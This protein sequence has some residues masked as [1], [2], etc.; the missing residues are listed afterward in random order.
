MMGH[1]NFLVS[2]LRGDWFSLLS[3]DDRAKRNFVS[4]RTSGFAR[5]PLGDFLNVI[6]VESQCRISMS[7][8]R[9]QVRALEMLRDDIEIYLKVP[10]EV[11]RQPPGAELV[12]LVRA[13]RRRCYK[14]VSNPSQAIVNED[15]RRAAAEL[16][17]T[18]AGTTIGRDALDACRCGEMVGARRW[19]D[20]AKVALAKA[21]RAMGG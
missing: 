14:A 21:L 3:S 17:E 12:K 13:S 1:W 20:R 8:I 6:E 9:D 7:L 10:T 18:W 11:A 16:A 2:Q 15:E 4:A 19:R 5:A